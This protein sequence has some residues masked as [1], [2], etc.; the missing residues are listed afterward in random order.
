MR[1]R[2]S[3]G[4]IAAIVAVFALASIGL[5]TVGLPPSVNSSLYESIGARLAGQAIAKLGPGGGITVITRDTTSFKQP[6]SDIVLASFQKAARRAGANITAVN[7]MQV[8]PLRPLE[9]PAGDF[10]E[11]LR[12][13]PAGSVI[14][15]FMGPPLLLPEQRAQLG[16]VKSSVVALCPGNLAEVVD[17]RPLFTQGLLHAA[18]VSKSH[19]GAVSPAR[20]S[21]D[22]L[23]V[24][25]TAED[26]GRLPSPASRA[27]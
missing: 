15:S 18:V 5:A 26:L 24:T 14:V 7:P 27:N 22:D 8:D 13:T 10:F 11:L 16:A 23:Y 2:T 25:V 19:P 21:F 1:N 9:V 12:R 3:T 17:L 20:A 6:A 4:M